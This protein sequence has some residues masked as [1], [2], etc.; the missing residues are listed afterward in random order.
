MKKLLFLPLFFITM[1][2]QAQGHFQAALGEALTDFKASQTPEEVQAL[3]NK[4]SRIAEAEPKEWLPAYYAAYAHVTLSFMLKEDH[5]RDAVLD[6]AQ[7]YLDKSLKLKPQESELFALQGFLHQARISI[8][9]M[10]RGMKYSGQA[11]AALEKAKTLNPENPRAYFLLG[12]QYFNMP[13]M[14]GGGKEVAKPFLTTAVAKFSVYHP[15]N[16]LLPSWG[17]SRALAL[18]SECE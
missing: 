7:T 5:Q 4:M 16:P 17:Q 3:A 9:P 6:K 11:L 15:A 2:V 1:L 14:I 18:L 8:A 10:D 13:Q 12:Q